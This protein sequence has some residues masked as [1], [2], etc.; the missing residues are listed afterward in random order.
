MRYRF[1]ILPLSTALMLTLCLQA[2]TDKFKAGSRKAF[3]VTGI[4]THYGSLIKHSKKIGELPDAFPSGIELTMSWHYHN[5][6]SFDRCRCFPR[7]GFMFAYW[8]YGLPEILGRGIYLVNYAEP[9]FGA[10]N[11]TFF[12]VRA[13][14]GLALL[15]NPYHETGN[16]YNLSYSSKINFPLLLS[17]NLFHRLNPNFLLNIGLSYNH[18]SNGGMSE[19]NLGINFPA[20]GLG[21]DY[22]ISP[23]RFIKKSPGDWR[24]EGVMKRTDLIISSGRKQ[25]DHS[26]KQ[27]HSIIGFSASHSRQVGRVSALFAGG[28][29][30]M[31]GAV[32]EKIRI[33]RIQGSGSQSVGLFAGHKFLLGRFFFS[34]AIGLYIY[35]PYD[36]GDPYYQRYGLMFRANPHLLAG[37][38]LKA[39]RH[40]ADHLDLR[41]SVCF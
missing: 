20:I 30:L 27:R 23:V 6:A 38:S 32:R 7:I 26:E 35:K 24:R 39:H 37:I 16:P 11:R 15:S 36:Y 8:N 29:W 34:Q 3:M 17:I 18:V 40:V 5:Q 2:S 10:H 22:N 33:K 25:L 31:D 12:S 41:V 21:I 9:F 14:W 1:C 4:K 28:E 13:A 19:P